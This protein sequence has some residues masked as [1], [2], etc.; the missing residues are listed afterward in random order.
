MAKVLL[1]VLFI[2]KGTLGSAAEPPKSTAPVETDARLHADGKGWRLDKAKI[3]DAKRPRVLLIGDSILNG[4][5]KTVVT[6]LDGVAYVDAWVNPY[7][8]AEHLNKTILPEVLA[9]GPYDVVHFNMGLHGWQTGRIKEGT[10]EPLTKAYVEVIRAKMPHARIIWAS[11][12]PVTVKDKPLDLDPAI[13]DVIIEHNRMAAKVMDELKVPV[14]DFYALLVE[15]RNLARGDGF[16]WNPPAY[17]L[18][19]EQVL[20]SVYRSLP[21]LPP[22]LKLTSPLDYQVIQRSSRKEGTIPLAGT[23]YG[24]SAAKT[25]LEARL[26]VAGQADSWQQIPATLERGSFKASLAGPAGGW[27]RLEVRASQNGNV[28]S[29][30]TVE[31]LGVGEVFVV[32]GQS[33]SA[34][35]GEEKQN[36]KSDRVVA[37]DGNRWQLARDP[38]PG[39]SGNGGSFI[40]PLGD[41]LAQR[42]DVP[43]GF[44]CCGIGATSVREWLPKGSTFPHPPT[45]ETRVEKL[46]NGDWASKGAAFDTLVSRMKA[47]GPGGFRAVLWHQGESDANQKDATR[48]LPGN[49]YAQYLTKVIRDSRRE[50]GWEAP[51]FV[52]QVSYHNSRDVGTPDIREAQ[53][54]LWRD[55]LASKGPDSDALRDKLRERNGQGVH[56]SGEGLREH[57]AKWAEKIGPW[58]EQQLAK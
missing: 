44:I 26:I 16:H 29:E 56:F 42:L 33:N 7:N 45:I 27:H 55:G 31:H 20:Q 12:T 8:Q 47:A 51:W 13:N 18:L 21:T 32:A 1:F 54:S 37:F 14:N 4:Y 41:L 2:V 35:H 19:A 57:G 24:D 28:I 38:Q 50:I 6:E 11:S 58:V 53:A 46:P 34:N 49:L 30:T 43:I 23:L 48:T 22:R 15:K 3:T 36:P 9:N 17:K 39:A 25:T 52:A 10:F 40:P 5:L